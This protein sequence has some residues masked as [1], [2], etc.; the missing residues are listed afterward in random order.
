MMMGAIA[1]E[2]LRQGLRHMVEAASP[3]EKCLRGLVFPVIDLLGEVAVG[4]LLH[5]WVRER[6][7]YIAQVEVVEGH[8]R[9]Y[10]ACG[11]TLR[12]LDQSV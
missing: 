5:A 12:E 6:M 8:A 1:P 11:P 2:A 4:I 3:V 7:L 10:D 9:E